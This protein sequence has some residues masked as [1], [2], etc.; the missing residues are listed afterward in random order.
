[1]EAGDIGTRQSTSARSPNNLYGQA[2]RDG[3]REAPERRY[4]ETTG[5]ATAATISPTSPY[6]APLQSLNSRFPHSNNTPTIPGMI[7]PAEPR[8]HS[9]PAEV[10]PHRQ[11]LP[12]ISEVISSTT[13]NP[14]SGFSQT[15]VAAAPSLA[16][17][18]PSF[19]S[20]R[21]FAESQ[22][23]LDKAS[24]RPTH[25]PSY[26]RPDPLPP[27]AESPRPSS[28][29]ARPGPTTSGPFG[30]H[31]NP[32][33]QPDQGRLESDKMVAEQHPNG[34]Y[35][36]PSSLAPYSAVA[37]L[38]GSQLTHTSPYPVSP[39]HIVPP[40]PPPYESQRTTRVDESE[41]LHSRP[42][43]DMTLNRHIEAW[44]YQECLSR[45]KI[46][47]CTRTIFNFA[48]GY[49]KIAQEQ[50]TSRPIPERLPTE[51][52]VSDMLANL[53]YIRR[54]LE[55]VRDLVQHSS[56]SEVA[57]ESK[58]KAPV[59]DDD[60]PMYDGAN[61]PA[62]FGASEVKKRRGVRVRPP[63]N[64]RAAPPG[65]CHSCNRI[66]TP[67]WR[68]GPDGARTLC[69]AC[70]LHYAKLERKRQLEARSIR[71]RQA[72]ETT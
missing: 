14:P 23:T 11:S 61:K 63:K 66:D 59:E 53:D 57:R 42:R 40:L 34:S 69:N 50:H 1:M 44:T 5:L 8:R 43:Y 22:P 26:S 17:F 24:S 64:L 18:P 72:D 27:F 49:G 47:T 2:S 71:P 10:L 20:S 9:D 30:P 65:R 35:S 52:E 54:S 19:A 62:A 60:S 12:S 31:P 41:H 25:P 21:P 16:T 13:G 51:R 46:A 29:N 4:G 36:Q 6:P 68:R 56:R 70:G 45:S 15:P 37:Q 58:G 38:S 33:I 32:P 67:E 28:F 7:T 39:R 55:N 48:E 3:L